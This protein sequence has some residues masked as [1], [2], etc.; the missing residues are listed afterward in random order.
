MIVLVGFQLQFSSPNPLGAGED[1]PETVV[2]PIT[3]FI[4][5]RKS[6]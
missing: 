3:S 5:V 1:P 2:V 4:C 6:V